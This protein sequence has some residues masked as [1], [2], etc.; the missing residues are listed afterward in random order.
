MILEH[1]L[2]T[3]LI[4]AGFT[5]SAISLVPSEDNPSKSASKKVWAEMVGQWRISGQPKRG[6][7]SGA[8]TTRSRVV[9]TENPGGRLAEGSSNQRSIVLRLKAGPKAG[10]LIFLPD[11][12]SGE[13]SRMNF[14]PDQG[15]ERSYLR[16]FEATSDRIVFESAGSGSL[17]EER[18]TF[19]QRSLDR[20][21]VMVEGRKNRESDW[22]R[23]VEMGMTRDGTTIAIGDGQK[24]CVVTGGQADMEVTIAGK[25]YFVCCSGCRDALLD[26]PE[27]FLTATRKPESR[28]T[29]SEAVNP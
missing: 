22:S 12:I 6:S 15:M 21:L 4:L 19:Q 1:V 3:F 2:K 23:I 17:S 26:D 20:W 16:V 11:R 7:S 13:F 28:Q 25:S 18:W 5:L 10:S 8:W 9:W 29:P 24:K 14:M 27:A